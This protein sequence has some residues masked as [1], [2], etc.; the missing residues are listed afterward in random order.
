M[1]IGYPSTTLST[2]VFLQLIIGNDI[3][4]KKHV[5]AHTFN[6]VAFK[7]ESLDGVM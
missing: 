3:Q 7:V 5:I 2:C 1:I 4:Q 6:K